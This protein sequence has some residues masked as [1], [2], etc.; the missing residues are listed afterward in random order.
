MKKLL[1]LLV[2]VLVLFLFSSGFA[3]SQR[4]AMPNHSFSRIASYTASCSKR[5]AF[6]D[7]YLAS[8][9]QYAVA[10]DTDFYHPADCSQNWQILSGP[11]CSI[12]YTFGITV[13]NMQCGKY[14]TTIPSTAATMRAY[15]HIF[16]IAT[17]LFT[18]RR[19]C[20]ADLTCSL[21][22]SAP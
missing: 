6:H 5:E 9:L 4:I 21:T 22:E 12:V 19:E 20:F 3:N 18:M 11:N 10:M 16:G 17:F 8:G 7:I 1:P 14:T 13:G 15:A 2:I